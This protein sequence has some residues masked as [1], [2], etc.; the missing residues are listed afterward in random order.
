[1]LGMDVRSL[2]FKK[3]Q[4]TIIGLQ[5]LENTLRGRVRHDRPNPKR[6]PGIPSL[7]HIKDL[8]LDKEYENTSFLCNEGD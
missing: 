1:M 6:F 7:I 5:L 2:P 8:H 3:Y 4:V